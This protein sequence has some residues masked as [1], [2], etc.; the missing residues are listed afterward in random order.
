[1]RLRHHHRI[2]LAVLAGVGVASLSSGA[3]AVERWKVLEESNGKATGN[4][5]IERNGQ[6]LTGIARMVR[7]GGAGITYRVE[8]EIKDG[9]VLMHRV[10]PSDR[11][12][13]VYRGEL[14]RGTVSGSALCRTVPGMWIVQEMRETRPGEE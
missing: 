2:G 13:C 6:R 4:W 10:S 12:D 5:Y 9:K 7:V 1:M 3:G 14:G 8:G 11:V